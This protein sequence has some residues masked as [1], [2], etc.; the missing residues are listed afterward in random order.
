MKKGVA[1]VVFVVLSLALLV[2]L[3]VMAAPTSVG[4]QSTA[5][6]AVSTCPL[7]ITIGSSQVEKEV[8]VGTIE[9]IM[10]LAKECKPHFMV[11]YDKSRSA[12]DV[13]A[14]FDGVQP[15]FE[16]LV[17]NGLT[18]Y[19]VQDLNVLFQQIRERV[20]YHGGP[21]TLG[22]WNGVP[23]PIFG[24]IACGIFTADT[25]V[26]GLVLGTHTFI[27]TIGVDALVMWAGVGESVSVGGLG[28]TTSTGPDSGV[29]IGFVGIMLA[30]PIVIAGFLLMIGFA[31]LYMGAGP[32][33][34]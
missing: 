1:P 30:T 24:N 31:A 15:F 26:G 4:R 13:S 22:G 34:F 10:A 21:Q 2:P 16:A 17:D 28:F 7:T 9:G 27:P 3:S 11:I 33:P 18:T 5:V 14:A 6:P 29:I 32:A 25:G 23:T 19:S 8:P 12:E 20:R